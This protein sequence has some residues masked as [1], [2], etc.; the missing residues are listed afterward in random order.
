MPIIHINLL[1]GRTL[2]Q[3]QRLAQRI[4]DVVVDCVEVKREAVRVLI[5]ELDPQNWYS[6]GEAKLPPTPKA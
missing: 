5:H 1:A 2:E 6:A 3:K 4:T